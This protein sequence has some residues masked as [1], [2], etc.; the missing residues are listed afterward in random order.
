MIFQV[1]SGK[2]TDFRN[3][4]N[5]HF[6]ALFELSREKRLLASSC[7]SVRL[8]VHMYQ[9]GSIFVGSDI[10]NFVTKVRQGNPNLVKFGQKYRAF[11]MNN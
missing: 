2:L 3:V 9:H 11:Y 6:W 1:G 7:M 10:W 8:F 4:L 5:L